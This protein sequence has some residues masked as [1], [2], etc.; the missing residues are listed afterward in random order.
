MHQL[1]AISSYLAVISLL[2]IIFQNPVHAKEKAPPASTKDQTYLMCY[3]IKD[4]FTL[5]SDLIRKDWGLNP[6]KAYTKLRGYWK[7]NHGTATSENYFVV[8]NIAGQAVKPENVKDKLTTLCRQ[9][10]KDSF[11]ADYTKNITY[12]ASDSSLGYEYPLLTQ[13][14]ASTITSST[15]AFSYHKILRY[16]YAAKYAYA[17]EKES[18]YKIDAMTTNEA[19]PDK[20][21]DKVK[22]TIKA[23]YFPFYGTQPFS[24]LM[25]DKGKLEVVGELRASN[26]GLYALAIKVPAIADKGLEEEIIIAYK[27]TSNLGDVGKDIQLGLQNIAETNG[28]WQKD[29]ENF[30]QQ[31]VKKYPPNKRSIANGYQ[32]SKAQV[33]SSYNV[34]ITG[35]SLGA[36][37]AAGVG[38]RSGVLTRVFSSPGTH[39]IR[40][41]T[42]LRHPSFPS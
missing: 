35:H 27:G 22:A 17:V 25:L 38:S 32:Q 37:T 29:A 33:Y 19:C 34:V 1:Q 4:S 6:D 9:T 14:E 23:C 30:Y 7:D 2:M 20:A 16:A 31:I 36:Y 42:N 21:D 12:F 26:S 11:S 39:I 41:Y 15:Q 28:N 5:R 18:A 3:G 13:A 24:E 40:K 10:I 8:N